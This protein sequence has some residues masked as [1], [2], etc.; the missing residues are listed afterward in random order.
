MKMSRKVV[1][2]GLTAIMAVFAAIPTTFSWFDHADE[3][4]GKIAQ[5]TRPTLPLS[6]ATAASSVTMSTKDVS[7]GSTVS[8]IN[9]S[10]AAGSDE[11]YYETTFTN[12]GTND[13][14]VDFNL[15]T[16]KNLANFYIGTTSP[17][18]NKKCYTKRPTVNESSMGSTRIYFETATRAEFN[19]GQDFW[20][21]DSGAYSFENMNNKS[22][23]DSGFSGFT[24]DMNIGYYDGSTIKYACMNKISGT[25]KHKDYRNGVARFVY[26]YDLPA[27]TSK[28][29]FCNHYYFVY[30][31]NQEWNKT[32]DITNI[33]PGTL[34]YL[35]GAKNEDE[36]KVYAT[37]KS[38]RIDSS[39]GTV[40]ENQLLNL[41][42][43]YD[44]VRMAQGQNVD[45]GLKE[46]EYMA[47][48]VTYTKSGSISSTLS[49]EGVFTANGSGTGTVTTTL[50]SPL[51][52]TIITNTAISV[53]ASI[54]ELPILENL[55]V[56]GTANNG[57]SAGT[58]TVKWY[59][60]NE[61]TS[62]D[63]TVSNIYFTI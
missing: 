12:S 3:T 6:V 43:K 22:P 61:N 24:Y 11:K 9:T 50:T 21:S 48:T 30:S 36:S 52:D 26:W 46:T 4:E 34:Y 10:Y 19:Y 17:T 38:V 62:T 28:F 37:T 54:T 18:L 25:G 32:L 29:F 14:Y 47:K 44:S 27:G 2:L 16:V 45:L 40:Y 53:P 58:A 55:K 59:L 56:K 7:T 60:K 8:N 42:K 1:I 13:V 5:Y 35:T 57:G 23:G 33:V 41:T 15:G 20:N 51:G 31:T 49:Q 63:A 39:S